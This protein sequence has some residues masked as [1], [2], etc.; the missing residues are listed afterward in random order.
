MEKAQTKNEKIELS[1]D[2][3]AFY[4]MVEQ[5]VKKELREMDFSKSTNQDFTFVFDGKKVL[6]GLKKYLKENSNRYGSIDPNKVR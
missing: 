2:K 6:E 1:I 3:D 4:Q 5:I